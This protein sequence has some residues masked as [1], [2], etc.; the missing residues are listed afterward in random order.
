M[1]IFPNFD[2][3]L[4]ILKTISFYKKLIYIKANRNYKIKFNLEKKY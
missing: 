2:G 3:D 1:S 4:M